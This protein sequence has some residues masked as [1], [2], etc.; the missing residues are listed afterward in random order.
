[1][2]TPAAD[3]ATVLLLTGRQQHDT[4]A[5]DHARVAVLEERADALEAEMLRTRDRLHELAGAVATIHYLR[6]GLENMGKGLTELA[7]E[8]RGLSRTTARRPTASAYSALAGWASVIIAV[9]ALIVAATHG[10]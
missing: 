7:D 9:V 2:Q 5:S 10:H 1:M 4:D 8:V 3:G 6:D